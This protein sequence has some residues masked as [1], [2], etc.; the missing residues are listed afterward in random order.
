MCLTAG[1]GLE[2][3]ILVENEL[4]PLF[5]LEP[6]RSPCCSLAGGGLHPAGPQSFP[7]SCF[8]L[9]FSTLFPGTMPGVGG[10]WCS[11]RQQR[12]RRVIR[13]APMA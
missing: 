5:P 11:A 9:L 6:T 10:C 3:H 4:S 1:G 13:A 12:S 8:F 2:N 7:K